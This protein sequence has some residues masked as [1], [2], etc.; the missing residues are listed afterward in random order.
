[1]VL[2]CLIS[3]WWESVLGLMLVGVPSVGS[4]ACS[5][6]LGRR[7]RLGFA[8]EIARACEK[9]GFKEDDVSG[10]QL[11]QS[12]DEV[13]QHRH[14]AYTP[15]HHDIRLHLLFESSQ[16]LAIGDF[17]CVP[18]DLEVREKDVTKVSNTVI[19]INS[20]P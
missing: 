5:F 17:G 12:I 13:A 1:M 11:Q 8:I 10:V 3:R 20:C 15:S 14:R 18:I 2:N 4:C 6:G 16:V 7:L 9:H 19:K